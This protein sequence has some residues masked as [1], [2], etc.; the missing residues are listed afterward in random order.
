MNLANFYYSRVLN[1]RTCTIIF[2]SAKFTLCM[3]LVRYCTIIFP[4][5]DFSLVHLFRTVRLFILNIF[6]KLFQK[7]VKKKHNVHRPLNNDSNK[8]LQH[9]NSQ[10]RSN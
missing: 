9:S 6:A 4:G 8:L 1:N 2:F 7:T 10:K 3:V 5:P